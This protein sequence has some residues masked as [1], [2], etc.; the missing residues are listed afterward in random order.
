MKTASLTLRVVALI[1]LTTAT[2]AYGAP[3]NQALPGR[4][5]VID[6]GHIFENSTYIQGE[7]DKM[8]AD[9]DAATAHF[10]KL[11]AQIRAMIEELKQYNKGTTEYARQE[12]T[13]VQK[14]ADARVQIQLRQK[15]LQERRSQVYFAAYQQ[16]EELV[17]L[18]SMNNGIALVLRSNQKEAEAPQ[19]TEARMRRIQRPVVFEQ[20][21]DITQPILVELNRRT[22]D[23]SLK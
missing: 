10:K 11:E 14:Q 5:A 7:L 21:V 15:Q 17:R 23:V 18:Y 4:T 22:T 16:V 1:A 20:N 12:A 6:V 3:P 9:A 8:R 19:T 2:S 13:I